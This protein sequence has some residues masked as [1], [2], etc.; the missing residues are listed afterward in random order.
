MP[1]GPER[2]ILH[3]GKI[4]FFHSPPLFSPFFSAY[5]P[6][7]GETVGIQLCLPLSMD[8]AFLN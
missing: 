3:P 5:R 8:K 7:F 2:Q 6:I 4:M 1:E